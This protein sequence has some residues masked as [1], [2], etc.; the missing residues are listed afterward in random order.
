MDIRKRKDEKFNI[1]I[2]YKM[3][4]NINLIIISFAILVLLII[5]INYSV[6]KKNNIEGVDNG[7]WQSG[8]TTS[9]STPYTS[10]TDTQFNLIAN[11]VN[12]LLNNQL[13]NDLTQNSNIPTYFNM[14][15]IA[16]QIDQMV[17][18]DQQSLSNTV[19]L[20]VTGGLDR[21]STRLNSSH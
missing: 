20:Q 7:G 5:F 14:F 2:F 3:K 16:S 18:Y 12:Y 21:K 19:G 10:L 11:K 15:D 8:N 17:F 9:S 1:N 13:K 6:L 4:K